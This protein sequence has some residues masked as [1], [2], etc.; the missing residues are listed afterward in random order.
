MTCGVPQGS[1]LGPLLFLLYINDLPNISSQLKFFLFADDTN[2]YFESNDLKTLEKIVNQELGS[3]SLWLNVNRL[4]LNVSKTNFII[5][6]SK[7]K[8]LNHNVTLIL[9]RKA[10]AQKD[11]VKYLGVLVDQHLTWK[12]QISG[13]AKKISRGVGILAK[14]RN[15]VNFDI[16]VNIYYCLVYSHLFYGVQ[17]WGSAC[18]TETEKLSIL[19][20]KAVRILTGNQ[21]FQIYGEPAVPLPSSDP[22]FAQ[23]GFLK[24]DDI[25]GFSIA[26]FVYSTLCGLSPQVFSGWFTYTYDIHSY[27]TTS[28]TNVICEN[29]FDTGE[30]QPSYSL[31]AQSSRLKLYGDKLVKVCGP[32]LWNNI[33]FYIQDANSIITF[34]EKL[35]KYF[36][37]QYGN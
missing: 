28:S 23:L 15:S 34:K 35:K 7:K 29:Y 4:A 18:R 19:Q 14:L 32:K 30:E 17:A 1:V 21:Y 10:I 12:H 22:L 13:V 26:T 11:H 27:A 33:P 8:A 5:F 3:L 24:F 2:I 37:L 20:K 36:L 31:Y 16:L 9:N 25:F 6:R